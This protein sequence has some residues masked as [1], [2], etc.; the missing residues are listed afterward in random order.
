MIQQSHP[1]AHTQ[2]RPQLGK[3]HAPQCWQQ[4]DLQQPRHGDNQSVHQQ[5]NGWRRCHTHTHTET[6]K[7][8]TTRRH[9]HTHTHTHT[10]RQPKCPSTDEWMEK[11]THTHTHSHTQWNITQPQKEQSNAICGN[12]DGPRDCHT[13]WSKSEKDRYRVISLISRI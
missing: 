13:D 4:R 9:T 12:T 3:I 7:V 10:L 8:S 2:R 1:W 5:R 6:T 11:T